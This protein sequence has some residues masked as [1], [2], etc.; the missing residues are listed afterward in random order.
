MKYLGNIVE[1]QQLRMNPNFSG[2]SI[3]QLNQLSQMSAQEHKVFRDA[4]GGDEEALKQARLLARNKGITGMMFDAE[5]NVKSGAVNALGGSALTG[6]LLN[7][8]S[9][10]INKDIVKR[11]QGGESLTDEQR[12]VLA[13]AGFTE[14]TA[15]AALGTKDTS[16]IPKDL[17]F[18]LPLNGQKRDQVAA[19]RERL[20]ISAGEKAAKE[21]DPTKK[22][23]ENM[24]NLMNTVSEMASPEKFG[25]V[26]G[27]AAE[28]FRVPVGEFG[29]H[30]K[31]MGTML[32]NVVQQQNMMLKM[33][34]E[35]R[36]KD[37]TSGLFSKEKE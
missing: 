33:M 36:G 31:T 2:A 7:V 34:G 6:A 11:L 1:R 32:D 16:R 9:A 3:F 26:V 10:G 19:D 25:E 30:V 27:K 18:D 4:Q 20:K 24:E 21:L 13:N 8:G 5:G 29:D 37:Y 12:A 14:E 22:A 17:Q 23:F 15:I 35:N 28:D